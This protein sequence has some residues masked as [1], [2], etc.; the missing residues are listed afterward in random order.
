MG[1]GPGQNRWPPKRYHVTGNPAGLVTDLS[2]AVEPRCHLPR[3][4]G[5]LTLQTR[6]LM[7]VVHA[8][9]WLPTLRV[10][11]AMSA[12]CGHPPLTVPTSRVL[13]FRAAGQPRSDTRVTSLLWNARP[14]LTDLS[15]PVSRTC[16]SSLRIV[17]TSHLSYSDKL[18]SHGA[19]MI[20]NMHSR[21]Y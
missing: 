21:I 6:S 19:T 3:S 2:I 11:I 7:D 20:N 17:I 12:T 14:F 13:P 18:F 16:S 1:M 15:K 5:Y 10:V 9:A 8:F 4:C